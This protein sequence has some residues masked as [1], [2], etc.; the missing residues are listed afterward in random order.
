MRYGSLELL[1]SFGTSGFGMNG[2]R[3]R[4]SQEL[5]IVEATGTRTYGF[6]AVMNSVIGRAFTTAIMN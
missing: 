4:L 2:L 3:G 1:A 6:P 5:E